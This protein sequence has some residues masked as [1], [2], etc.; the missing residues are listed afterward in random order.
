MSESDHLKALA[1][2]QAKIIQMRRM[3]EETA[4]PRKRDACLRV[5]DAVEK[6][7]QELDAKSD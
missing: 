4:D 2:V 3:A 5:A 1:V 6:K 7:A